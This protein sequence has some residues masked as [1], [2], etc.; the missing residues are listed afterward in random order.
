MESSV[1]NVKISIRLEKNICSPIHTREKIVK[2]INDLY[3]IFYKHTPNL[4]N[5]TGIRKI[6]DVENTVKIVENLFN[7]KSV[8]YEINCIMIS[9]KS[10]RNIKLDKI[11]HILDCKEYFFDYD[12]EL[13]SGAFLK[14][15]K[16][17]KLPTILLFH[18]STFQIFGRNIEKMR[19]AYDLIQSILKKYE[20][21][22]IPDQ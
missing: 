11:P 22:L 6:T 7:I 19:Y 5:V 15:V 18:T 21:S 13:F 8:Y 10:K 3:I 12:Q 20:N 9:V 4:A 17:G 1:K 2:R 16:K 14:P